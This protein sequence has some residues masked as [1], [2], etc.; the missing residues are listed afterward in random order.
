MLR[1]YGIMFIIFLYFCVVFFLAHSYIKYSYL[2]HIF[3]WLYGFRYSYL[4]QMIYIY[5]IIW[6]QLTIFTE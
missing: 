2:I 6:L 1:S 3:T 5:T 4:K